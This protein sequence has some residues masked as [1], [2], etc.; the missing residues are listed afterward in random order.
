MRVA[1]MAMPCTRRDRLGGGPHR[2]PRSVTNT[3]PDVAPGLFINDRV[4]NA[5][6]YGERVNVA[7]SPVRGSTS[8][9]SVARKRPGSSNIG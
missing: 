2:T 5:F 6:R 8:L 9:S 1:I 4:A 3:T 7:A